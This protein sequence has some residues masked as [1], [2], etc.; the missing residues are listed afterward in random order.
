MIPCCTDWDETLEELQKKRAEFLQDE[1][2]DGTSRWGEMGGAVLEPPLRSGA[3]ALIDAMWLVDFAFGVIFD[4]DRRDEE[5]KVNLIKHRQALPEEAF[6][7]VDELIKATDA[8]EGL[9]IITLSYM[10]LHPCHP[11]PKGN[12]LYAFAYW[13]KKR[14]ETSLGDGICGPPIWGVFWDYASLLQH[15]DLS[16]G[17]C[18]SDYEED[19]FQEG[20]DNLAN[21]FSHQFTHCYKITKFPE[22]DYPKGL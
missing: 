21:F 22:N 9:H 7:S 17:V 20:L 3:I 10:W 4:L 19:L 1:T 11:D 16:N 12:T 5:I 18:R 8:A 14:L 6:V 2:R 13:L 15:P